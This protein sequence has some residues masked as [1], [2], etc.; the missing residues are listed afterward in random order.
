MTQDDGHQAVLAVIREADA[1][2]AAGDAQRWAACFTDDALNLQLHRDPLVG[3]AAI[4][5]H[6]VTAFARF[7]TSAWEPVHEL[8]E[9][10]GD[11]AWAYTTYTERLLE[12][13][14]GERT[15]VRGRL[16]YLFRREPDGRW[17]IRLIMNSHS[18]PM[19]PIT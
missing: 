7:D 11:R 15:L 16:V 6:W 19:A 2:F 18:R 10:F 9:A 3:R 5:E 12:R 17:A 1:A 13:A 4:L 14:T 8:V